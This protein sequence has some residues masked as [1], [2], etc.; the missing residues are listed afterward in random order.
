M[1]GKGDYSLPKFSHTLQSALKMIKQ[2][3]KEPPLL[4]EASVTFATELKAFKE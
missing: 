2:H 3:Q 1:G 4:G